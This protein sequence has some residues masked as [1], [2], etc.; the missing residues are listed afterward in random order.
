MS[1]L[2]RNVAA[3]YPFERSHRFARGVCRSDTTRPTNVF[4]PQPRLPQRSPETRSLDL[5]IHRGCF[6][7]VL[8][9]LILDLLPLVERAQS[10]TFDCRDVYKHVSAAAL[11]LS[12]SIAL[13]GLNHFTVPRAIVDL[14]TDDPADI[15]LVGGLAANAATELCTS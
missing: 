5:E 8:F 3:N 4:Q 11:R 14:P 10:S 1:Q 13:V 7:A 9:D 6:S 12:K 15:I 2:L